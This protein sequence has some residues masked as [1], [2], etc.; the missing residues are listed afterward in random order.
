MTQAGLGVIFHPSHFMGVKKVKPI[1]LTLS[2]A[3]AMIFVTQETSACMCQEDYD[4][5][6]FRLAELV[7]EGVAIKTEYT[8]PQNG[9]DGSWPFVTTF[10]VQ[11]TYKGK[12]QDI[13]TISHAT[14]G[15][16]YCGAEFVIGK[17]YHVS[18]HRGFNG[19]LEIHGCSNTFEIVARPWDSNQLPELLEQ[20]N[21][22]TRN[23]SHKVSELLNQKRILEFETSYLSKYSNLMR[24]DRFQLDHYLSFIAR[25][26]KYNDPD[27]IEHLYSLAEIKWPDDQK[28]IKHRASYL[29]ESGRYAEAL[30]ALVKALKIDP[31]DQNLRS[32]KAKTL[33]AQKSELT[34]QQLDYTGLSIADAQ[35]DNNYLSYRDFSESRIQ[36]ANFQNSVLAN[37]RFNDTFISNSSFEH[38]QLSG[39]NF[40]GAY[41]GHTFEAPNNNSFADAV[42]HHTTFKAASLAQV[43]FTRAQF[44]QSDFTQANL[45]RANFTDASLKKSV[46]DGADLSN[47][48]LRGANVST[49]S[50]AGAQLIGAKIDCKTQI[51]EGLNIKDSQIIWVEPSC[52]GRPKSRDFSNT[53]WVEVDL[54]GL[55]LDGAKFSNSKLELVDF[56]RSSLQGAD[57]SNVTGEKSW[58]AAVFSQADLTNASFTNANFY[59]YFGSNA[60]SPVPPPLPRRGQAPLFSTIQIS[61]AQHCRLVRFLQNTKDKPICRTFR[62]QS[63]TISH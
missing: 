60:R 13:Q 54:S 5:T 33:L 3:L 27:K 7:F 39:A 21:S 29:F 24:S 63:S 48:N 43:N 8:L 31:G 15:P 58:Q 20:P 35:L 62:P 26:K 23:L 12:S 14:P 10:E 51:P 57:F 49:V 32:Q 50:L 53:D 41:L 40:S 61:P 56:R 9:S 38:S 28:L 46:L 2:A 17:N 22:D 45:R 30:P 44:T 25:A 19:E 47:A 1:L 52:H 4:F 16:P 18:V 37:T 11:K 42:G 36:N 34:P 59:P 6:D 55:N